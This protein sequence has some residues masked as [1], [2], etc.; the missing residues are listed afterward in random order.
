MIKRDRHYC[1]KM[2]GPVLLTRTLEQG[3][4]QGP[5]LGCQGPGQGPGLRWQGPGPGLGCQGPGQ[6][7]G[8]E[9][10]GQAPRQ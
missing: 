8:L 5:G 7:Q 10:E 2:T 3:P 6:G 1:K 9:S 4:G